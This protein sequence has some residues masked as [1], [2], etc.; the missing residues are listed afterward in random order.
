MTSCPCCPSCLINKRQPKQPKQ[1]KQLIVFWSSLFVRSCNSDE[2]SMS[3]C[4]AVNLFVRIANPYTPCSRIT[5]SSELGC[6]CCPSCLIKKK[7]TYC[8][9]ERQHY[10]LSVIYY[11]SHPHGVGGCCLIIKSD[12][13]KRQPTQPKQLF[14]SFERVHNTRPLPPSN[15]EGE[16]DYP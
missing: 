6:P 3:I 15:L 11:L 8:S 14:C 13:K 5:N 7:T 4:N 10:L 16:L 1:P 9:S 2:V 12:N